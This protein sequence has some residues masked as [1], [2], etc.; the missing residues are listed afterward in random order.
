MIGVDNVAVLAGELDELTAGSAG[1]VVDLD[2]R[3][4]GPRSVI[5]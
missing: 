3:S 4:A 1:L 2:G 5:S